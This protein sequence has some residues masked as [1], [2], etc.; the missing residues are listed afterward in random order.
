LENV[1][2]QFSKEILVDMVHNFPEAQ[3]VHIFKNRTF[4]KL[5]SQMIYHQ[6]SQQGTL[7]VVQVQRKNPKIHFLPKISI[8]LQ[9]NGKGKLT[10]ALYSK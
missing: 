5:S 2:F 10:G 4:S 7:P 6:A 3:N 9:L 8:N 1:D